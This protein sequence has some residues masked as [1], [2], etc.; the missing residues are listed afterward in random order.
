MYNTFGRK[1]IPLLDTLYPYIHITFERIKLFKFG[2]SSVPPMSCERI[3]VIGLINCYF[4]STLRYS[5]LSL[6]MEKCIPLATS[7]G[8]LSQRTRTCGIFTDLCWGQIKNATVVLAP[9]AT[10]RYS[11]YNKFFCLIKHKL[12]IVNNNSLHYKNVC[13]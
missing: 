5:E 10:R 13:Y 12:L 8:I 3:F 11:I 2:P 7:L 9:I 6:P 4:K 1:P